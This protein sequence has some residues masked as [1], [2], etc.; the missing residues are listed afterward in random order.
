MYGKYICVS[1]TLTRALSL[2]GRGTK[3]A[4]GVLI[5]KK[6]F[7][8]IELLVVVL[9]IA[10][11]VAIAVPMYM[12]TVEKGK[13]TEI[14]KLT[15]DIYESAERVAFR[16]GMSSSATITKFSGLDIELRGQLSN[17][18]ATFTNELG[19]FSMDANGVKGARKA[20]PGSIGDYYFYISRASADEGIMYCCYTQ[21]TDSAKIC[22]G[23][24][25]SDVKATGCSTGAGY[26]M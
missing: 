17:D 25:S 18:D 15:R 13:A 9:V 5:M 11:L 2:S 16:G 21:N 26:K 24:S 23:L 14:V 10:I 20:P 4:D 6:G 19:V 22:A 1:L 3:S 8:L 7:T 12:I